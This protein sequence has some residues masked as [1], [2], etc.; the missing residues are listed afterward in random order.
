MEKEKMHPSGMTMKRWEWAFKT[1]KERELVKKYFKNLKK[2]EM[3][4]LHG[5]A[6][7]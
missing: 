7:F 5:S 6:P 4:K 1:P 2:E 3:E